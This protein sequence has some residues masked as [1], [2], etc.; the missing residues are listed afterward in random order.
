MKHATFIVLVL[1]TVPSSIVATP[2][3]EEAGR[4]GQA[5]S[6]GASDQRKSDM[7]ICIRA[8][9]KVM[10]ATLADNATSRD[11]VSILPLT[12]TLEDHAATEKIT[13]LPRKLSTEGAPVG[14]NPA[15][16]D[17]AY[18]AP[19]GNLALFH[20]DFRYSSGLIPLGKIDSG[21]EVLSR[22]GSL[23][24]MIELVEQ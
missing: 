15:I 16:G 8:G 13:Y 5:T 18:Y 2:H 17:V 23:T 9:D 20:K 21:L 3:A 10:T 1:A 12:V 22:P 6:R 7:R 19:W 4:A 24:A 11:F 14:S